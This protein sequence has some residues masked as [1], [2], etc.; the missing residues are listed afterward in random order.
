M[1]SRLLDNATLNKGQY[2]IIECKVEINHQVSTEEEKCMDSSHLGYKPQ[3]QSQRREVQSQ[4]A[5]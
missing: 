3:V 1:H 4:K 5:A 2:C